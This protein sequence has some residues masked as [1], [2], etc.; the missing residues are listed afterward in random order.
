[1][2]CSPVSC[3]IHYQ[4]RIQDFPEEGAPTLGGRQHTILPN[5]PK[6]LHEIER[7]WTPGGRASKILLCRS[8]TDYCGHVYIICSG[9]S[10]SDPVAGL[11]ARIMKSMWPPLAP[12]PPPPG[13]ATA[14]CVL[15]LLLTAVTA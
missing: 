12:L 4:W 7:I 11:G 8:A 2:A 9:R 15:R 13:S 6:K 1:M 14:D 3:W 5:F 10:V